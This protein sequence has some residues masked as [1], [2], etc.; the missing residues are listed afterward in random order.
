MKADEWTI[1]TIR[2]RFLNIVRVITKVRG[3]PKQTCI[4]LLKK[5]ALQSSNVAIEIAILVLFF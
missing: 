2:N 5:R 1:V 3:T 4:R